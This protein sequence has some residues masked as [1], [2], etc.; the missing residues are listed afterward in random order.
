MSFQRISARLDQMVP[1]MIEWQRRLTA[2]PAL[3]PDNGGDGEEEKARFLREAMKALRP[4]E[5][6]EINAPDK[7]VSCGFRPNLAYI[8]KGSD[9]SRKIW[10]LTHMDIVP[11]GE[12]RLWDGDP[13]VLRVAGD[14][15]HGRGVEDNQ[16]DLVSSVMGVKALLDEGLRPKYDVG[17]MFVSDEETG[18]RYGLKYVLEE[19]PGFFKDHDLIVVPDM[20]NEEGTLVEVAEKSMLW[21]RFRVLGK[22]CHASTPANGVNSLKAAAGLILALD[23]LHSIFSDRDPV[24]DPPESTFE[25][26]KKEANVPNVNTIPGEDVF[27]MDSRILPGYDLKDILE[28]VDR[29]RLETEAKYGVTIEAGPVM[30]DQ[31]APPTDPASPVVL[32]LVEAVKAVTG[33]N[34][35]PG[36]VGGGTVAAFFRR[37]GLPAAVW[38]TSNDT[39]HQPN[40]YCTLNSMLTD[41]KVFA[42]LFLNP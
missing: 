39:A 3:G 42:H 20:G 34:A 31:A 12:L 5:T 4:D 30:N 28:E 8:W 40:E 29:I 37:A 19:R 22:Q 35:A 2:I 10:V 36:G 14:R 33:T 9:S 23:R 13:Y 25:C 27:Y 32:S 15:I 18:S 38:C 41:A 17:L 26:T 21:M 6:H 11:P 1:E 16:H 24:F 7:R